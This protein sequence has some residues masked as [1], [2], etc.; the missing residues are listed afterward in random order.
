MNVNRL[1]SDSF[2]WSRWRSCNIFDQF[3]F[4]CRTYDILRMQKIIKK[5]VVGYIE[6]E[7]LVCRKKEDCFG[8]MFLIDDVFSWCHLKK[9]EF[10]KIFNVG[11]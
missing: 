11:G 8:V 1:A 7:K 3:N 9:D 10:N 4:A 6:G 5:Y 2:S